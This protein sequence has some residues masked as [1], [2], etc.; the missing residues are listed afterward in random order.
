AQRAFGTPILNFAGQ[1]FTGVNPSDNIGDTGTLYYVQSINGN[2]GSRVTIYNKVTGAVAFGPFS[3][4]AL[5]TGSCAV[6]AG[7]PGVVYDQ[8]ASRWLLAEFSDA[9]NALC[10]YVSQTDDPTGAYFAYQFNTPQFPDY[11]KFSVWTDGYYVT[12][13]ESSPAI[14]ALDRAKMLA[15][16]PATSQRFTVGSMAGFP[17]QALTPGDADGSTLPPAGAPALFMRHRD[18]EVHNAGSN[19]PAQDFV[20]LFQVHI[21]WVTPGNS[22]VTGPQAIAMAEFDS[23]LCGLS[24]FSC[25]PQPSGTNALD[26]LREVIMWR[27]QYRNFGTYQTMVGSFATDV[28]GTD[29]AGVRW[30]EVRDTGSGWGLFQAGTVTAADTTNRWMSTIAMDGNGNIALGYDVS[31]SSVFPGIR[32]TGRLASD[33]Q[34]VMTQ[35]EN[36]VI[37]GSASNASNRWGDY[38]SISVDPIDDCTFWFTSNYS[39]A[40]QWATRISSFKFDS[41]APVNPTDTPTG[42]ITP[43]TDTPTPTSVATETATP[44]ATSDGS[45]VTPTFT[46]TLPTNA[47]ELLVNGSF[48]DTGLVPWVLKNGTKDK[49][50]CNNGDKI[51]AR[52]GECAFRFKGGVGENSKIKQIVDITD[53]LF[54]SGDELNL[55]VYINAANASLNARMKLRV[56]FDDGTSTGKVNS[57]Y[58]VT[59]GY[60]QFVGSYIL[61]SASVVKIKVQIDNKSTGGK[62]YIDDTSLLWILLAPRSQCLSIDKMPLP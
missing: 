21:D 55:N 58:A 37:N 18:D 43:P 45:T 50:K 56:K 39:P 13:N 17:F 40:A 23:D 27:L 14:Y 12:T 34:G 10:V 16:Q 54:V 22:S 20:D 11:P 62:L 30:F 8:F 41:C 32:Y 3:M 28:D 15:G 47:Q 52:T 49:I 35:G 4:E 7:D 36:T 53:L 38:N 33:S 57:N 61:P 19:N 6:G 31:S 46:P 1:G 26:P 25:I 2:S 9:A 59:D 44:T 51:F 48:E 29:R 24:S 5:G 42:T 60:E